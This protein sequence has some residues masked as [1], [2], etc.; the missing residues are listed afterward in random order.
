[1]R[2][3]FGWHTPYYERKNVGR[4]RTSESRISDETL[5]VIKK[6][7]AL[8]FMLYDFVRRKFEEVIES[9]PPSFRKELVK[10]QKMNAY[11]GLLSSLKNKIRSTGKKL[12]GRA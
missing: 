3:N 1:M 7:N 8:D 10:F 2:D 12:I 9:K 6:Y 4:R 11:Y 5:A